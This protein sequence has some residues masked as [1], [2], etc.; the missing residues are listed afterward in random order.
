M[1]TRLK[2]DAALEAQVDFARGILGPATVT[3]IG[4]LEVS[5]AVTG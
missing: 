2:A 1:E 3:A 5:V 4:K